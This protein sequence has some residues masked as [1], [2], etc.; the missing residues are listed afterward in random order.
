MTLCG[1]LLW[2]IEVAAAAALVGEPMSGARPAVAW[3][4]TPNPL[5]SCWSTVL[6]TVVATAWLAF[7]WPLVKAFFSVGL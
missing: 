4:G 7:R 5:S 2:S 3:R 1:V 6:G